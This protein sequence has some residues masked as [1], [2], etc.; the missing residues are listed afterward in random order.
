MYVNETNFLIF[1]NYP[2]DLKW[3]NIKIITDKTSLMNYK[4]LKETGFLFVAKG[5]R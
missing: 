4:K 2:R 3:I 5:E 1:K